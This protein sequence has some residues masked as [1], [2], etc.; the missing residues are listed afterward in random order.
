MKSDR[1]QARRKRVLKGARILIPSLGISVD[2][3]V[4][5]LSETGACLV[6]T[7][8]VAVTDN[9]ELAL[10]DGAIRKCSVVWRTSRRLGVSFQ[11]AADSAPS[12]AG[13]GS[14]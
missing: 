7:A 13:H 6:L 2:C 10:Y 12:R 11:P 5:D 9:F 1:R 14:A 8:P 3:A 4:R